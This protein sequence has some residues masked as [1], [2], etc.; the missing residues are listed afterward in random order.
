MSEQTP[1][2][3]APFEPLPPTPGA[4][5]LILVIAAAVVV[6]GLVIA[7]VVIAT[8][9][10]DDGGDVTGSTGQTAT[11]DDAAADGSCDA[12]ITRPTD[13]NQVH[14]SPG[15]ELDY[16][17]APPSF[18]KHYDTWLPYSRAF[19]SADRPDVGFLVHNLEHGYTIVWYDETLAA[20]R[21][22]VDALQELA[23]DY[24][25]DNT[26]VIVVPWFASDGA[27][28]PTDRHLAVTRWTADEAN[29]GDASKQRG[30]WLYC[31]SVDED[32]IDDFVDTWSNNE[33]AEPGLI[34]R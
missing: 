9:S 26:G 11:S 18:G 25:S 15:T 19:Y 6:L 2:P 31:G 34:G 3:D 32:A 14:V 28:F 16:A 1:A 29:P 21:A 23:E 4:S 7:G 30:N 20:D 24:R 12:V 8:N 13:G 17:D 5:R 10:D 27:P 22:A 33:S